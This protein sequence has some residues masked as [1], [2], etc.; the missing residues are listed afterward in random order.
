MFL[1]QLVNRVKLVRRS[2]LR[3]QTYE[4]NYSLLNFVF[5]FQ[6]M[7]LCLEIESC[8]RNFR[9]LQSRAFEE[10]GFAVT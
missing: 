10:Y 5:S 8:C 9:V 1:Q 2:E 3:A 7:V 6:I 4:R